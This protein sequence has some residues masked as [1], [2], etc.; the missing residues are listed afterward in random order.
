MILCFLTARDWILINYSKYSKKILP[1]ALYVSRVGAKLILVS[2]D[3]AS[4]AAYTPGPSFTNLKGT[5]GGRR[6]K[7]SRLLENRRARCA[8]VAELRK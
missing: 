3:S 7:A 4:K 8:G 5:A 6:T 2:L 1:Y